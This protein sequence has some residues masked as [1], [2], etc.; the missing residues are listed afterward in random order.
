MP[1]RTLALLYLPYLPLSASPCLPA[2]TNELSAENRV[3][4]VL[5]TSR[6]PE[7]A[8]TRV[9]SPLFQ[10]SWDKM[11]ANHAGKPV[12]I[13]PPNPLITRLNN[14]KWN[15]ASVMPKGGYAVFSGPATPEFAKTTAK[16]IQQLFG[17]EMAPSRIPTHHLGTALYAIL[18]RNL[19]FERHFF[20]SRRK[21]LIFKDGLGKSH[22]VSFF[23]TTGVHSNNYGQ[24][25]KILSYNKTRKTFILSIA[26]TSKSERLI[27]Y[28]PNRSLPFKTAV[29]HINSAIKTPLK[30]PYGSITDGTLH[31]KDTI[32]IP[33]I[34]LKTDTDF[35]S[36]LRGARYYLGET[37]PSE[38]TVAYQITHFK[39]S[40][41]GA[42]I[43]VETHHNDNP[44]GEL[45]PK[46]KRITY[47]PR[48]FI[49][50]EPFFFFAWR[51]GATLPYF[52][53]WIDGKTTLK[54]FKPD[55]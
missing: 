11:N 33:Y 4:A 12:K 40:E 14:F 8:E 27:I 13:E 42:R 37:L 15:Q 45:L 26:T 32:K 21:P 39:L 1:L 16:K 48:Q 35:A 25:V 18:I 29:K 24:S 41:K 2:P 20:R 7:Q 9:W 54:P 36:L 34:D 55:Q 47:I 52:A 43:R 53:A 19:E 46:P 38:T 50:D 10:A 30:G 51:D 5:D 6:L 44:F 28:R 23:G 22:A 3:T 17:V 31:K 49:C